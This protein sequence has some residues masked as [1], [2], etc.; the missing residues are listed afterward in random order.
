MVYGLMGWAGVALSVP[1]AMIASVGVGMTV[2][3]RVAR[4][5]GLLARVLETGR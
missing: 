2:G 4:M 3:R 1:T 5:S